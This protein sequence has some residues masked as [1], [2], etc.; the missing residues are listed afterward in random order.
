M[1]ANSGG[2]MSQDNE[3]T[4]PSGEKSVARLELGGRNYEFPIAVGSEGELSV[5]I[6]D[7]R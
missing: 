5:E 4:K 1:P 7:L 3:A 2:T 6:S